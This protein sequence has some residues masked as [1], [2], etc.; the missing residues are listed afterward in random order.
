MHP[1]IRIVFW[2]GAVKAANI[3]FMCLF[4]VFKAVSSYQHSLRGGRRFPLGSGSGICLCR[5]GSQVYI[6]CRS[7]GWNT[8]HSP[9]SGTLRGE[10]SS[11]WL[12]NS[13]DKD[14]LCFSHDGAEG[15]GWVGQRQNYKPI[16]VQV[17][18]WILMLLLNH[19]SLLKVAVRK[20]F[21]LSALLAFMCNFIISKIVGFNIKGEKT[22]SGS[23]A[24]GLG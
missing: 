11:N 17:R 4:C 14:K 13:S 3:S 20:K 22:V 21:P 6:W 24:L 19:N 1:F 23:N 5:A 18:I 8:D 7:L 2:L 16:S 12:V 9:E 15:T 10:E